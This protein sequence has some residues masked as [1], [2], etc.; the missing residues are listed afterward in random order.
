MILPLSINIINFTFSAKDSSAEA[1]HLSRSAHI[2]SPTS[3]SPQVMLQ[4]PCCLL[5]RRKRKRMPG[6]S[7]NDGRLYSLS[8]P[9]HTGLTQEITSLQ[10]LTDTHQSQNHTSST[11]DSESSS[12]KEVV[13][14]VEITIPSKKSVASPLKG[15]LKVRCVNLF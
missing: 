1:I 11:K 6:I 5:G 2:T 12:P 9:A 8:D 3:R 15:V 7:G 13:Q 4:R 14:K 10:I